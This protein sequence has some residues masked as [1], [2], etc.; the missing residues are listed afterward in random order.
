MNDQ[1]A[2]C[3]VRKET[4]ANGDTPLV[5]ARRVC[6]TK[7]SGGEA[8]RHTTFG[9]FIVLIFGLLFLNEVRSVMHQKTP[10][11]SEHPAE[12]AR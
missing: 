10:A 5:I 3:E 8:G 6:P 12:D 1:S 4:G 11:T 7:Q 2:K 9:P